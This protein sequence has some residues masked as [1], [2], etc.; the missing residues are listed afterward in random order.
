[1]A[2]VDRQALVPYSAREMF[3]LVCDVGSYPDF[4]P[5]CVGAEVI[6]EEGETQLARLHIAKGPI[7]QSF[8]TRNTLKFPDSLAMELLEGPFRYLK[9]LWRFEALGEGACEV[10]LN[11]DFE[12]SSKVLE[13]ALGKVF[14]QI[15]ST[16]VDAF[17]QR[18]V[19]V[20]G[21]R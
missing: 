19:A 15:T 1:M 13:L 11:M 21:K 7:Q 6:S 16:L 20:Y 12:F 17:C 8:A 10:H 4:L 5:W 2:K 9:G 14:R 18:A 3:E